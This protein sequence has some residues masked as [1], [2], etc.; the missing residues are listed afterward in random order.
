MARAR[1]YERAVRACQGGV[2]VRG[3]EVHAAAGVSRTGLPI[4]PAARVEAVSGL[5][6]PGPCGAPGTR[7]GHR[8]R[9]A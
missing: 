1:G 7:P 2:H 5:T 4:P 3:L 9:A 6:R 8:G